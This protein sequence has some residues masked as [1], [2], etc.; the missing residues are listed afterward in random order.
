MTAAI[1]LSQCG[2]RGNALC[3]GTVWNEM[4]AESGMSETYWD[5]LRT[6]TGLNKLG[7]PADIV[8]AATLLASDDVGFATSHAMIANGG[9]TA[10]Q[11]L[12]PA[13]L[14]RKKDNQG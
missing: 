12:I 1:K 5:V 9:L 4:S 2:I 3:P 6:D 7:A 11:L 10:R 13:D 14:M 8:P